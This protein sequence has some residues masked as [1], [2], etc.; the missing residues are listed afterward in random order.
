MTLLQQLEIKHP[1]FLAP[2]AGVSTPE[3]AAE[4]SNQGGLGSLGLGANTAQSAR[5]QILKTQTLTEKSFQVNFFCHHPEQLNSQTSTQWIEYLRPQFEKFGEQPP[6]N[7]N[8]IYPS[9]L[10]NDDFLN[11]VLETKPKAVSFHFGIPHPDQIQALKDAGIITMVSA[12]NLVEAQAIEAA[13]IDIIIAQGIEAGGH[14]GIFNKTFDAAIKT[15]DLV[16]LIVQHCKRPVVA[17]GG[18]MNGAQARHMLSLGAT[19]VQLGTAFVQCPSSNASAEYRKALF[20]ESVTQIS[21]SLSGRPARGLLNHW[22]TQIDL[23]DRPPQPEYPYTYDLA[24]QLNAIASKNKDYGFGAFWAGSNVSQI[25]E[26]DAADL[27]NQLV[28]EMLE[29][30]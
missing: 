5:E 30:E 13:G 22:H 28:V 23:P 17:A 9:F 1:I 18:I 11:V 14:R 16:H 7:L 21:A 2:M 15:S 20:N 3:L 29:D 25:R 6:Q 10:D 27:V 4:V 8:C 26:L 24:K 12:T 19:A